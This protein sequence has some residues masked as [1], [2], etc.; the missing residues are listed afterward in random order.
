ML[1][2][3]KISGFKNLVDVDVRFGPFTCIA[4]PNGVGK[5]NLFDAIRFL[6]ALADKPLIEAAL[7]VRDEGGRTTD[8]R[9]IFH[10]TA[11]H[12]HETMHFEVEM[13]VPQSGTDD[14]G[15][16]AKASITFLQYSLVIGY[17]DSSNHNI[18]GALELIK[19]ELSHIK[20]GDA[21]K[22]L[23]FPHNA[24]TWRRHAV[25]GRR[26]VPYFIST[27][28]DGP[29]RIIK[30]HQDGGNSGRPLSRAAKN[31][32][33]TVLSAAN[34]A[35]S[36]TALM[37]R[38][39]MQSWRLLQLEP[40]ALREPDTFTAPTSIGSNGSHLASTLYHLARTDDAGGHR[41]L[42]NKAVFSRVANRLGELIEDV[43]AISV[44]IDDKR[45]LLTLSV[46]DNRGTTHAARS[47]SDGTLRFLALAVVEADPNMN[48]VLCLE[49]PENGIHP[50]RIPAM[51]RLL[52]DIATDPNEP[53]DHTSPLRQVII[54]THSPVVVCQIPEDSLLIAESK[55]FVRHGDHMQRAIFSALPNTWRTKSESMPAASLGVILSYLNPVNKSE[56]EEE[57]NRPSATETRRL[58]RVVDRDDVT[59]FLPWSKNGD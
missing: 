31:L 48:G 10:R 23:L 18:L 6:S 49:E 45:E 21:S 7:S 24:A 2:R 37:A 55:E 53:F 50:E 33:R 36:P 17:R 43:R 47:L 52:Q 57:D 1:T 8:L 22:H 13:I 28:G 58:R 16:D 14:L 29:G 25:K 5:S 44:D 4:G 54:N 20:I 19:E 39:E 15:Q 56:Y 3:L 46:T 27:E 38:R 9:T 30:L 32:P 51:L 42:I 35:E 41:R 34:A 12:Y 26:S 59:P 40:S 11:S